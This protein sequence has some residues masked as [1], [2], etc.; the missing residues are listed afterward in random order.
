MGGVSNQTG[1]LMG[2]FTRISVAHG[3]GEKVYCQQTDWSVSWSTSGL[4]TEEKNDE[5]VQRRREQI[6]TAARK[7]FAQKG[8]SCTKTDDIAAELG[9]GKGTLYR[10]F[11]DKKDL[12]LAVS[13]EGFERLEG[14]ASEQAYPLE[15]PRERLKALLK[16]FYEFFDKEADHIEIMMQLRGEFKDEYRQRF[17]E[18]HNRHTERIAESLREGAAKGCFRNVDAGMGALAISSLLLGTLQDFYY[19]R[20]GRRLSDY[21]GPMTDFVM[22]GL[23]KKEVT[24]DE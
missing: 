5:L 15:D 2:I 19:R 23:L 14:I 10:Y 24:G 12:F 8:Y 4:A 20:Q 13:D 16:V 1:A 6:I 3:G 17:A 21:V 22:N 9:V 11:K 7:V 18:G